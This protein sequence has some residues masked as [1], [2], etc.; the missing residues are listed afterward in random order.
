MEKQ[1]DISR[2]EKVEE[3]Q[4]QNDFQEQEVSADKVFFEWEGMEYEH[5]E[6]SFK[7][8]LVA[9]LI[10][11]VVLAYLIY[12]KDWFMVPIVFIMDGLLYFYSRKKPRTLR[13]R[14]TKLGI[15][16]DNY[17]YP[18]SEMHSFWLIYNQKVKALNLVSL[19]KYLP[20]FTISLENIDPLKLRNFL[21]TILPEQ[22]K[23]G[24]VFVDKL[25]R[26]LKM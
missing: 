18:F 19:K 24:E 21:K 7:F 17:F 15:F 22:E 3:S 20:V 11:L 5:E 14:V 13:Y 4:S 10:S 8:F 26:L 23:R 25:L 12:T 6:K 1:I 9:G 16:I 2:L